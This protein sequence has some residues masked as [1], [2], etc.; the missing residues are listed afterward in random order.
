MGLGQAQNV[1]LNEFSPLDCPDGA[2]VYGHG[3]SGW[4][5]DLSPIPGATW[6]WVPYIAG[7]VSPA[8]S[9]VFIVAGSFSIPGTPTGGTLSIAVDDMAV[10]FVNG[11]LVGR[12]GSVTEVGK[13]SVADDI[14]K[15]FDIGPNLV[16]GLNTLTIKIFNGPAAFAGCAGHCTYTQNPAGVVFGGSISYE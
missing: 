6:I 16:S 2:T 9:S 12:W 15:S 4:L 8:E 5:A 14:L 1:C 3:G 10:V 13:A 7:D 11:S